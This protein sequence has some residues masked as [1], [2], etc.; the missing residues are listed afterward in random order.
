MKL[1]QRMDE[2]LFGELKAIANESGVSVNTV[3]NQACEA[4]IKN[5]NAPTISKRLAEIEAKLESIPAVS[6]EEDATNLYQKF[7]DIQEGR[8][9]AVWYSIRQLD[10]RMN[11]LEGIENDED[12]DNDS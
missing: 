1:T 10:A 7:H 12:N 6:K 4:Y 11:A 2:S 3:I 8:I 5:H 9:D